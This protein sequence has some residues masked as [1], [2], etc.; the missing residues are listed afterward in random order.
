MGLP[1]ED[2]HGKSHDCCLCLK[3]CERIRKRS[4]LQTG[5]GECTVPADFSSSCMKGLVF[6]LLA[7]AIT[8]S[9]SPSISPE[10]CIVD[11]RQSVQGK[12]KE[13]N[14]FTSQ[15]K[16]K[17]SRLLLLANGS[18]A[19]SEPLL[20]C[21]FVIPPRHETEWPLGEGSSWHSGSGKI[22]PSVIYPLPM[23]RHIRDSSEMHVESGKCPTLFQESSLPYEME[24]HMVGRFRNAW[25]LAKCPISL[26]SLTEWNLQTYRLHHTRL[27]QACSTSIRRVRAPKNMTICLQKNTHHICNLKKFMLWTHWNK[28]CFCLTRKVPRRWTASFEATL[29]YESLCRSLKGRQMEHATYP[30]HEAKAARLISGTNLNV[31]D[32]GLAGIIRRLIQGRCP[33]RIHHIRSR[34]PIWTRERN[35]R[36]PGG[37][38]EV[39]LVLQTHCNHRQC[40]PLGI[41]IFGQ[42]H[43][44]TGCFQNTFTNT[45]TYFGCAFFELNSIWQEKGWC[46]SLKETCFLGLLRAAYGAGGMTLG[47]GAAACLSKVSSSLLMYSSV[48]MG[49]LRTF[50][51]RFFTRPAYGTCTTINQCAKR[52]GNYAPIYSNVLSHSSRQFSH[53][54]NCQ[55]PNWFIS[56]NHFHKKQMERAVTTICCCYNMIWNSLFFLQRK[57]EKKAQRENS[58]SSYVN[59]HFSAFV[60]TNGVWCLHSLRPCKWHLCR[61][62]RCALS[63][64]AKRK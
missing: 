43:F 26:P 49:L 12:G 3:Q 41:G 23:E 52:T 45:C 53:S 9:F 58:L 24:Q 46:T 29:L 4:D 25:R 14:T 21:C 37:G 1:Q 8:M 60:N 33:G 7:S 40:Q 11:L 62:M 20:I 54:R 16:L 18:D 17:S 57:K 36:S 15:H 64:K 59:C 56:L 19:D 42:K 6:R 22:F 35:F 38:H 48:V 51:L 44:P 5:W 27:Q 34:H 39:R 10:I 13:K 63:Q 32:D 28:S 2:G 47:L 31:R 30:Q 50:F 55:E 61:A